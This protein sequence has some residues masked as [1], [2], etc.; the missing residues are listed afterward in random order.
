M[1]TECLVGNV[2]QRKDALLIWKT[3]S[4]KRVK[5]N[6]KIQRHPATSSEENDFSNIF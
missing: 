1:S 5:K 2:I 3:A 4:F 6:K